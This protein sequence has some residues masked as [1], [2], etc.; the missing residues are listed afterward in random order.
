MSW[1]PGS[2]NQGSKDTPS[3]GGAAANANKVFALTNDQL[4]K[5]CSAVALAVA[6]SKVIVPSLSPGERGA[7]S[8]DGSNITRH[9]RLWEDRCKDWGWST[10]RYVTRFPQYVTSSNLEAECERLPGFEKKDWSEYKKS[11]IK[12]FESQDERIYSFSRLQTLVAN[13]LGNPDLDDLETYV[14]EYQAISVRLV[15]N[16]IITTFAQTKY[17]LEGLPDALKKSV[18]NQFDHLAESLTRED[19]SFAQYAEKFP[20]EAICKTVLQKG[21]N[22]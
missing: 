10:E 14:R 17:L 22:I 18:L 16:Q 2:S 3:S 1:P 5:L 21:D 11:L 20:F 6:P 19:G 8:F 9:C 12:R 7:P 4:V 15:E 13:F